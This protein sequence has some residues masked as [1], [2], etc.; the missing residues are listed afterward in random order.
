MVNEASQL[1]PSTEAAPPT[2]EETKIGMLG[3]V[4]IAVN[5][6]AGPAILQLPY[7]YQQ[8]GMIPTTLCLIFVAILSSYCSLNMA[9]TI[10]MIPGNL[11][12]T[13]RVEFSDPFNEFG[14]RFAY[15]LTQALFLLN[16]IVLNT[17]AIIDTAEVLDVFLGLHLR[18]FA[19]SEQGWWLTW[20]HD[21]V[22]TRREVKL[23]ACDPFGDLDEY[24]S[25]LLSLG[26]VITAL[27]FLPICLMDLKEG[28]KF[29]IFGFLITV[30]SSIYFCVSFMK[31]DNLALRHVSLMG[32][33]WSNMLG[34]ILFN[35]AL[36]LAIP[37]LLYEKSSAVSISRVIHTSTILTTVLYVGVGLLGALTISHVNVNM[38]SPMVSGAYGEGVQIAASCF[39]FFI[40]GLDIPLFSVLARYNLTHSGLCDRRTA[41]LA[42]VW[43]PWMLSWV[44]YQG[45]AIGKLL[46]WG[47]ILLTSMVAFL[48]P[49]YLGVRA[50]L[51]SDVK[52][53][54]NVYGNCGTERRTCVLFTLAILLV[55][56]VSV[57]L[58]IVGHIMSQVA[59]NEYQHSEA[60][61]NNA[62]TDGSS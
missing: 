50:L 7:V 17:A 44:F 35:F 57:A 60:Y 30:V 26:Y 19:V 12:F 20:S 32:K 9:N 8:S 42:V 22:C 16:A 25:Y 11:N 31:S 40:I 27:V 1:L 45:D 5:A 28:T 61:Y 4:A 51:V 33:Q 10:S 2:N 36:V 54:I 6:L 46:D 34:V 56:C 24:G 3:T 59:E 15:N 38:L 29:Q 62:E 41:N 23:G 13:K 52:G 49:L 43:L 14:G 47:G 55:V 39:A 18:T 37:S 58:A 21:S 53:S 48:L